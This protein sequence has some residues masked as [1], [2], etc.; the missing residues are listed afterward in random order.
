MIH[1]V[2]I[3]GVP[4]SYGGFETLV[5]HLLD[6]AEIA[7]QEVFVYCEPHV[8]RDTG[9]K[10]KGASLVS[11]PFKANGWQSV[12]YD[13]CALIISSIR[14]GD[15]LILGTSGTV[16]VP[17]LRVLFPRVHFVVNMAGLEW[18]R[19]K[20][21]LIAR[22]VIKV[23]EWTGLKYCHEI[24]ADNEGLVEYVRK[25]Y[26]REAVFIPYGGDQYLDMKADFTE[27]ESLNLAGKPYDYAMARVQS[28]NNP[29]LILDAYSRCGLPLVFVANW[30][31][32]QYG[33]GLLLKYSEY[34]NLHMV[35][36]FYDIAKVK[37]IQE[38]ARLYVHGHSAGGTN[39][40]LVEAMWGKLPVVA[41]DVIFNR[42]T[43]DNMAA[44]FATSQELEEL[45]VTVDDEWLNRTR[46][47]LHSVAKRKYSWKGV[48]ESYAK[49][50]GHD[51]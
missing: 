14:G 1:I 45:L 15:V 10:Y 19:S 4:G 44:Y 9:D 29:E 35:G 25:N 38:G 47:S 26:S 41:F 36:P 30:N 50:L 8:V 3:V 22:T 42:Y 21:G 49:L 11:I 37:G 51:I 27:V 46:T 24:I 34:T 12:I 2:G 7:E 16:L 17:L 39:P 40:V 32:S 28:D 13:S 31:S 48:L 23:N 18:S 5:D 43:T 6:S 20:W 33:R